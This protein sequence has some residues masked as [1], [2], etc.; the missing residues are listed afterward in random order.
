MTFEVRSQVSMTNYTEHYRSAQKRLLDLSENATSFADESFVNRD[1]GVSLG[2]KE[3]STFGL[4]KCD[5]FKTR[6]NFGYKKVLPT[7]CLKAPFG[8]NVKTLSLFGHDIA[9]VEGYSDE[10]CECLRDKYYKAARKDG[11]DAKPTLNGLSLGKPL[12]H[13]ELSRARA[14]MA[15]GAKNE[16]KEKLKNNFAKYQEDLSYFVN[17]SKEALKADNKNEKNLYCKDL[18]KLRSDI[19]KTCEKN[20]VVVDIE[21]ELSQIFNLTQAYDKKGTPEEF[22]EQS[23]HDLAVFKVQNENDKEKILSRREF[24]EFRKGM[25]VSGQFVLVD[26][27][28]TAFKKDSKLSEL[29]KKSF[30]ENESITPV[31]AILDAIRGEGRD[32]IQ[33][34]AQ[35]FMK[36]K[37]GKTLFQGVDLND[38]VSLSKSLVKYLDYAARMHPGVRVALRD[39]DIFDIK[40][41]S[42]SFVK[43]LEESDKIES[44]FEDRCNQFQEQ[45]VE[46]VCSGTEHVLKSSHYG[47]FVSLGFTISDQN[48]NQKLLREV[49]ICELKKNENPSNSIFYHTDPFDTPIEL[50]DYYK[51]RFQLDKQNADIKDFLAVV[52]NKPEGARIVNEVRTYV[53]RNLSAKETKYNQAKTDVTN[54][55]NDI[56]RSHEVAVTG[57]QSEEPSHAG[58]TNSKEKSFEAEFQQANLS[59][60]SNLFPQQF[61]QNLPVADTDKESVK[62]PDSKVELSSI[63]KDSELS[64]KEIDSHLKNITSKDAEELIRIQKEIAEQKELLNTAKMD[65]DKLKI[66]QLEERYADMEKKFQ[67]LANKKPEVLPAPQEFEESGV[68]RKFAGNASGTTSGYSNFSNQQNVIPRENGQLGAVPGD[69]S[70]KNSSHM[71]PTF[72]SN[73]TTVKSSGDGISGQG[74]TQGSSMALIISSTAGAGSGDESVKAANTD[75]LAYLTK[76]QFD[77]QALQKIKESGFIYTFEEITVNGQ[78]TVKEQKINYAELDDSLKKLIDEKL[79]II[80]VQEKN[81]QI[82]LKVLQQELLSAI[83]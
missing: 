25:N 33:K 56:R 61:S 46:A 71:I 59:Q 67:N 2:T 32:G 28:L 43:S 72:K 47:D 70:E 41:K 62:V 4:S 5:D 53:A 11:L 19:S 51:N 48:R 18:S 57:N 12:D 42:D 29:L 60:Q 73:E 3:T 37:E 1:V 82:S 83:Y 81:R 35:E 24:D 75:L 6:F 23:I 31:D 64:S 10:D 13:F 58:V 36:N 69:L 8:E 49:T 52:E 16:A 79:S 50:S 63:L 21:S 9:A 66:A 74:S 14:S 65:N 30:H 55:L 44:S 34:I 80:D 45:V 27:I 68:D 20:E 7:S 76:I 39:R 17:T 22:L 38:G 77:G 78:K 15:T 26:Q 40:M 54:F